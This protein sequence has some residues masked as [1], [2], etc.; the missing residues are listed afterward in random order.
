M[1]KI[2]LPILSLITAAVLMV[3]CSDNE[4]HPDQEKAV[5]KEILA[6]L[7]DFN[8][9]TNDVQV[10]K[11]N[12][13]DGTSRDRYLV[14]GDIYL[15][16]DQIMNF[17]KIGEQLGRNYRTSNLVARGKVIDIM[18]YVAN[19]GYGLTSK[20]QTALAMAVENFNE[21]NLDIRFNLTFGTNYAPKDMVVYVDALA[22]G[23]GGSAGFPTNGN[24]YKWVEI[25]GLENFSLDVVEHVITHEIGH[26]VGFRHT[27]WQTRQSCGQNVNEGDAGVGAIP[28][29]GTTAGY[30][31]TSLMLACFNT[32]VSGEFNQN[33]RIALEYLY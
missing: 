15:T 12:L 2:T 21:L 32:G 29:P 23:S 7:K 4:S 5:S 3:S 27:D 9:N 6:K 28:I 20:G 10:T 30:D 13:P 18:G 33:D 24:P 25:H 8:M 26:S 19:D 16:R 1:K 11:Q 17:E 31:P 22:G 14:E